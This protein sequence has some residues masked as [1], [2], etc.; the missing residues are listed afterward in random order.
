MFSGLPVKDSRVR[1]IRGSL[2]CGKL[3]RVPVRGHASHMSRSAD[4]MGSG[5]T[6]TACALVYLSKGKF[7]VVFVVGAKTDSAGR[8][9]TYLH[10]CSHFGHQ[11]MG[12]YD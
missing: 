5:K 1:T 10:S 9:R 8:A 12:I 4:V 3:L 2:L 7:V 6:L 11:N